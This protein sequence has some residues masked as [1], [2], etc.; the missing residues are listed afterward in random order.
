MYPQG[1]ILVCDVGRV[2]PPHT[3]K[4]Q[5]APIFT[6]IKA[7]GGIC[8]GWSSARSA[9]TAIREGIAVAQ[10]FTFTTFVVGA[11][12]PL[13]G[14]NA[15]V[16]VVLSCFELLGVFTFG[17]FCSYCFYCYPPGGG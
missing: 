13:F 16:S 14:E 8:P 3:A 10:M 1:V 7:H 9:P 12:D 6:C 15:V 11:M 5:K 4:N 17:Y 2:T